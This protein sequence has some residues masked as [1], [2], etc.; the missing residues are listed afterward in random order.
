MF[1]GLEVKGSD[2]KDEQKGSGFSF[3]GGS[4]PAPPAPAP[5]AEAGSGFSFMM[6]SSNP[7]K[8]VP[9]A[10]A[11]AAAPASGFG[12]M[13]GGAAAAAPAA[14]Q[15]PP[16][17]MGGAAVPAPAAS[18]SGFGFMAAQDTAPAGAGATFGGA[19]AQ[20][21][22]K[23]RTRAPKVGVGA[24]Y[25][26][27]G[28]SSIPE[29]SIQ[30]SNSYG[31]ATK[32]QAEEA[33]RRAEEF[34]QNKLQGASKL[35][36]V[37]NEDTISAAG[38]KAPSSQYT[39]EV[40]DDFEEAKRAAEEAQARL[41]RESSTATEAATAGVPA[42]SAFS[43]FGSGFRNNS[44]SER[45]AGGGGGLGMG[46]TA[47]ANAVGPRGS[48]PNMIPSPHISEHGS[49]SSDTNAERLQYEQEAIRKSMAE[50]HLKM[51]HE[52]HVNGTVWDRPVEADAT[53][54]WTR[55]ASDLSP[56][57]RTSSTPSWGI[58]APPPPPPTPTQLM[59]ILLQQFTGDVKRSMDKVGALR[60]QRNMLLEER[61]VALA[62]ERLAVQQIVQ[63]ESLQHD[64]V[65]KEDFDMADRLQVILDGHSREKAE[66]S[67]I[68]DNIGKALGQLDE[69]T[70]G[71]VN[72][73]AKCFAIVENELKD[74]QTKQL[75]ID[76]PVD[77]MERFGATSKQLSSEDERLN[78]EAKHLERD[79]DLVKMERKE[80][81]DAIAEQTAELEGVQQESKEQLENV[82][83]EMDE[84]RERLRLKETE[85]HQLR[86]KMEL[87]D[88]DIAKILVKFN[89][90]ITRVQKKESSVGDNR[91]EWL[92]EHNAFM[93]LKEAHDAEVKAHSDALLQRNDLMDALKSEIAMAFKFQ[94][95]ISNEVNFDHTREENEEADGD[96]AQLQADVVKCE[97][98]VAEANQRV[99]STEA[100][101]VTLDGESRRL[102]EKLPKLEEEKKTAAAKRDFRTAGKASKE[103]K[104]ASARLKDLEETLIDEAK[105]A[106]KDAQAAL[107]VVQ[108]ELD[109]E[110]A[111]TNEKEKVSGMVSM[112]KIADR[113]RTLLATKKDVC[114]GASPDTVKA[115]GALV[116]KGQVDA[117]KQEGQ[118]L[119][120]KFGGWD[121]I[122]AEIDENEPEAEG[123]TKKDKP[124]EKPAST[125]PSDEVIPDKVVEARGLMSKLA[126]TEEAIS[127]AAENEDYEK[128][129]ELDEVM[130]QIKTDFE[131]LD[132][133]D[134]E[135]ELAM[136]EEEYVPPAE[137]DGDDQPAADDEAEV[138][139]ADSTEEAPAEEAPAEE[140]PVEEAPVEETP[141]EEE[142]PAE[143]GEKTEEEESPAENGD[144][145]KN[146][147]VEQSQTTGEEAGET[148]GE[149]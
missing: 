127:E 24:N 59:N 64:A 1:G 2:K 90:Q 43:W 45:S 10:A 12:F 121:E 130:Q 99:K 76:S 95:I 81:D 15:P 145:H 136:S 7:P 134:A 49:R 92:N 40:D 118:S 100:T 107:E 6:S 61:F 25:A 91:K 22:I 20:K 67:A 38:L 5:A 132:L 47:L 71:V 135:T 27:P 94:D 18:P 86:M 131:E 34:M 143:N 79:E 33:V 36:S 148:N 50:R 65:E 141:V 31:S 42:K 112:E 69:Q 54:S 68:L 77:V 129:A 104:E 87:Q 117:L 66:C 9:P 144:P 110:R 93:T 29:P 41:A 57:A 17:F 105:E 53:P 142:E 113:I 30:S 84:L 109:E 11:D 78:G 48:D 124:T 80:L 32:D 123:S 120:D 133:T 26:P 83:R 14:D 74:F 73:V 16:V 44:G 52:E 146:E 106:R 55:S 96:L 3:M 70:P 119:G 102:L 75:A 122:M 39:P 147:D 8:P 128:A 116:L 35:G 138:V 21:N 101:L 88:Q 89:R 115:A 140:A 111:L 19:V 137:G 56:G 126:E 63:T 37:S 149:S 23:R 103:I 139:A 28:S 46:A 13:G 60:Q 51:Q 125:R 58:Q 62:K 72:G 98:A 114:G 82:E 4:A 108:K 97:A 85:A